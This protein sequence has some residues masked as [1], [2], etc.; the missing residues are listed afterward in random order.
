MERKTFRPW[1]LIAVEVLLTGIIS[2]IGVVIN[3]PLFELQSNG[4]FYL[5]LR[6]IILLIAIGCA[7][8]FVFLLSRLFKEEIVISHDRIEFKLIE[9]YNPIHWSFAKK[10]FIRRQIEKIEFLNG[11]LK[12][13]VKVSLDDGTVYCFNLMLY[14]QKRKIIQFLL[15]GD[16]E[17]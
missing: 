4:F 1:W 10:A 9:R 2:L 8:L 12:N 14:P 16:F 11:I 17:S 3:P 6:V 7:L 15:K 13:T 5:V